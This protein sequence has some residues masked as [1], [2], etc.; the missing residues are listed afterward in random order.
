[1]IVIYYRIYV[2]SSRIAASEAKSKPGVSG[3]SRP[4]S[5][6]PSLH[7][8]RKPSNEENHNIHFPNHN[9]HAGRNKSREYRASFF[10]TS[11]FIESREYK[12]SGF[13]TSCFIES[14]E[15]KTS[16]FQ[17]SCFIESREY[18]TSGFQTSGVVVYRMECNQAIRPGGHAHAIVTKLNTKH[19][20]VTYLFV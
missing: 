20:K 4:P 3:D 2:V 5:E 18:K 19:Y 11:S 17:T 13:Q 15:Y 1:M 6:A 9:G 8:L 14:R 16:G 12:T 10:Q 7:A